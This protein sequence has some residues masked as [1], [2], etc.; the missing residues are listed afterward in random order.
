VVVTA[1][2]AAEASLAGSDPSAVITYRISASRRQAAHGRR[3]PW[4]VS[5]WPAGQRAVTAL[6]GR[7]SPGPA[8]AAAAAPAGTGPA[9]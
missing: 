1:S 9:C 4:L 8:P 7:G 6:T 5:S 2:T 3:R